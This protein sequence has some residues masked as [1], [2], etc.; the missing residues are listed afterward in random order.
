[1]EL[2]PFEEDVL[3][4]LENIKF[5]DTKN[6]F[7]ETLA[8]DLKKINSSGKILVFA[9]KTRNI[10]ETSLDTSNKLLHDNITKTYKHGS[11]DNISEINNELKHIADKLSIGNRI[12]CMKKREAFKS[13]K[14]L[15]II[16]KILKTTQNAD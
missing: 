13:A 7:Q 3:K 1:M 6:H 11:E 4:L 5:R 10:Y 14:L 2:K 16:R 8:N 9:D 15:K 12:E